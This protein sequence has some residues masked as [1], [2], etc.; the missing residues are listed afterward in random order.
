M[1]SAAEGLISDTRDR[2]MWGPTA[3][4]LPAVAVRRV[5]L[6]AARLGVS[7]D[8]ALLYMLSSDSTGADEEVIRCAR[9]R[10]RQG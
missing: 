10:E 2:R 6:V 1:A 5:H 8:A 9:Q 7:A 3:F 4:T